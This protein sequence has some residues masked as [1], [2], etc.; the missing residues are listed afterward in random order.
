MLA[1]ALGTWMQIVAQ[2]LLVLKLTGNS[3]VA[4]GTV[5][6]A[7]ASA[8]FLFAPLG[9]TFADRHDKRKLLFRT[10]TLLML[11]AFA[12]AALTATGII[13]L[14]MCWVVLA[15]RKRRQGSKLRTTP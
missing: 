4:L 5:S 8:F 12:L 13:R 9:G 10:Q 14:W 15:K 3:A 11:I 7:Q 1:S 6:L 2:S